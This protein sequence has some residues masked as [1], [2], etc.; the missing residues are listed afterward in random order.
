[1]LFMPMME[2]CLDKIQKKSNTCWTAL[3]MNSG[4]KECMI[5]DGGKVVQPMS[6]HAYIRKITGVGMTCKEIGAEK[7]VCNLCGSQVC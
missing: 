7:V 6:S 5:M 2:H 4:K 3:K 1:M